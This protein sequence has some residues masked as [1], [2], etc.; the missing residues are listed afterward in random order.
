MITISAFK[1]REEALIS[2]ALLEAAGI[3]V[4][5]RD[6]YGELQLQVRDTDAQLAQEVLI[7]DEPTGGW[8]RNSKINLGRLRGTKGAGVGTRFCKG[9]FLVTVAYIILLLA[10]MPLGARVTP[11][12]LFFMFICGGCVSVIVGCFRIRIGKRSRPR[13]YS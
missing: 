6:E 10:L 9:G 1:D 13:R 5:L 4:T 7:T 3:P 11:F 12:A 2:K 8:R